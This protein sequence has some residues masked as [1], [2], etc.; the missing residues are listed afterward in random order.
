MVC[1][2]QVSV[3]LPHGMADTV[4]VAVVKLGYGPMWVRVLQPRY[5]CT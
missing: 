1:R 2:M 4:D 5:A 3:L